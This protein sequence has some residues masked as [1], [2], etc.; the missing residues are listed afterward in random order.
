MREL[1]RFLARRPGWSIEVFAHGHSGIEA[2]GNVVIHRFDVVPRGA[3]AFSWGLQKAVLKQQ[4]QFDV[5]HVHNYH[6]L[7]GAGASLVREA[8]VVFTPHYH[9]TGHSRTRNLL[10]RPYRRFGA[11]IFE[12]SRRIICVSASEASLVDE[13]FH[14]RTKVSVIPN[15]V[16]VCERPAAP[17]TVDHP[18]VLAVGR[19]EPYKQH[20]AV[21]SA[22][23]HLGSDTELVLIGSGPIAGELER[24]AS[25][26]GIENRVRIIGGASDAVL[27][28]W[29]ATASVFVTMS[30]HEAFGLAVA[31]ALAS[32]VPVVASDIPA[33][34]EFVA[35]AG[36]RLTLIPPDA[37]SRDLA[38]AI[39]R[40][41]RFPRQSVPL[42][43][44]AEVADR[45]ATEYLV[46]CSSTAS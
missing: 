41:M 30:R 26:L 34:R 35:A 29:F 28:R 23:R 24:V 16:R 14:V 42:T 9:G 32:G 15:G 22:A 10:H 40:G 11:R 45:V 38:Y 21:L 8:P 4:S 13:H 20:Q 43:T 3:Y 18:V 33:H 19:L 7:A 12:V 31:E 5:I 37:H 27:R 17:F 39:A 44:W 46:A 25:S 1:A 6:S 36:D 2:D